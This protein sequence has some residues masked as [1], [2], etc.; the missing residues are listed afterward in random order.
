MLNKDLLSVAKWLN[1]HKLT[2][3]LEKT[4]CLLIG[5]N[6]KL[7]SK[8]SLTVSIVDHKVENVRSFKYLGIIISTDFTWTEHV[9]NIAKK[10]NQR[11][12]LLERIKHL[13]PFKSRLLYYNSIVMPLF[14]YADLVWG[15]KHNSTLMGSLQV[16][17]NKAAKLI[18]DKSLHSSASSTK[19]QW[20]QQR[21]AYHAVKDFNLL[22][23][24]IKRSSNL[25]IFKRE[26]LKLY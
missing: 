23:R 12:G 26:I 7:E 16:L 18:S 9:E 11:L 3:N 21:T 4:K 20:G 19:R 6:R 5:S 13:L 14:D 15:D 2:L 24:D 10:I 17:Q 8:V 22:N 1:D 25:N